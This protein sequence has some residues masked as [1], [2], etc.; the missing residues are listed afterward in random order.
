MTNHPNRGRSGQTVTLIR[1]SSG[2]VNISDTFRVDDGSSIDDFSESVET[3]YLPVGYEVA[4]SA[5]G[6]LLIYD[7]RGVHCDIIPHGGTGRPQLWTDDRDAPVLK[8]ATA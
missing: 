5:G 6:I 4:A 7:R 1:R 8:R 2:F 3:Y